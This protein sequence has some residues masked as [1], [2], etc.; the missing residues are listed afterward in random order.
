MLA[1]YMEATVTNQL[2]DDNPRFD[3]AAKYRIVVQ[4]TV[5]ESWA[6][7][8]AGM[9][10]TTARSSACHQRSTLEGVLKDQADLNGVLETL[11]RLHLTIVNVQQL[12]E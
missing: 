11:Y 12:S 3:G 1:L 7:R 5:P 2:Q 6:D 8:L 4:G 9:K 10:V